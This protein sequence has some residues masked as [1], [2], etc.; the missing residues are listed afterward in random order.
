MLR[1]AWGVL[2]GGDQEAVTTVLGAETQP[3]GAD[4]VL[5][6]KGLREKPPSLLPPLHVLVVRK[7]SC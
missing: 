6:P 1:K 3:C 7:G 5:R 4:P 2:G